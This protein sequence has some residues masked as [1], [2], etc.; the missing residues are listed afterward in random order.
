M[1][2]LQAL[3]LLASEATALF[4]TYLGVGASISP[5]AMTLLPEGMPAS[6]HSVLTDR[7]P[8]EERLAVFRESDGSDWFESDEG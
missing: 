5:E 8:N 7:L 6:F 3:D 1:N 4:E 2:P